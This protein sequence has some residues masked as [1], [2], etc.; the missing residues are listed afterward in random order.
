MIH[1]PYPPFPFLKQLFFFFC[2]Q[3]SLIPRFSCKFP[4]SD[5]RREEYSSYLS[6][7]HPTPTRQVGCQVGEGPS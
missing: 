4:P 5:K 1:A 6:S 3:I 2:R 7:S